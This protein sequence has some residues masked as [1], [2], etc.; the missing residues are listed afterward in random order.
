MSDITDLL[1]RID[2]LEE[3]HK[4]MNENI[5][6]M[7]FVQITFQLLLDKAIAATR[8]TQETVKE[9]VGLMTKGNP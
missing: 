8:G 7:L 5:D 2:A 1:K 3:G 4:K 6:R 9:F